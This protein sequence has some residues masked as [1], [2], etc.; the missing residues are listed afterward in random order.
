MLHRSDYL[1]QLDLEILNNK[2]LE[3]MFRELNK[4]ELLMFMW[5]T[6]NELWSAMQHFA[7]G[8]ERGSG[9]YEINVGEK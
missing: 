7:T 5:Q 1:L 4:W 2:C 9:S 3:G 6:E 8:G